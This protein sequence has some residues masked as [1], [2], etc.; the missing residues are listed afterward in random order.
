[1]ETLEK[2]QDKIQKICD[3]LRRETIEPAKKEAERII[4]EAHKKAEEIVAEGHKQAENL[5]AQ[6][7]QTIE[8]ERN[9]FHSSLV[10]ASK[11]A[12]ESLRQSIENQLFNQELDR[13][14]DKNLADPQLIANLVNGLVKAIEKEGINTDLSVMIP[15]HA[16]PE[17]ITALLLQETRQ[18]LGDKPLQ[19]GH[20]TGG[21]QVK[22]VGKKM[23][24]DLTD[25]ALK[26]LLAQYARK[27]FRETIF[28]A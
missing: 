7:R 11:Q 19:L 3:Q 20:F 26:D 17:Q 24:I 10:Q 18:K 28:H 9:V 1:M 8:Q 13:V 5:V 14:L 15:R 4:A 12:L 2:G 22:L 21:I 23:T 27:D 25:Q 16:S 6:G